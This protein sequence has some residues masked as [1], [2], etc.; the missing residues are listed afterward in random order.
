[1]LNDTGLEAHSRDAA[2]STLEPAPLYHTMSALVA[3]RPANLLPHAAVAAAAG[4]PVRPGNEHGFGLRAAKHNRPALSDL[5]VTQLGS[6]RLTEAVLAA[7]ENVRSSAE[8][9]P[10]SHRL[11]VSRSVFDS[12]EGKAHPDSSSFLQRNL[13][14]LWLTC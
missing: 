6:P 12:D 1:M 3:Q 2:G 9:L 8:K 10:V 14:E 11:P 13:N 7:A 4:M 5:E